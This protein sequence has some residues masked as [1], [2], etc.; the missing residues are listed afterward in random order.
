M[1]KLIVIALIVWSLPL[2]VSAEMYRC[3]QFPLLNDSIPKEQRA[4]MLLDRAL[5]CVREG[6]PSQ[7]IALFSELIGLQ[8]TISTPT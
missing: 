1:V 3:G 2:H 7:S 8:P 4:E 5:A 6:K